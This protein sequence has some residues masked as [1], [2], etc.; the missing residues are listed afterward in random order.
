MEGHGTSDMAALVRDRDMLREQV[1]SLQDTNRRIRERWDEALEEGERWKDYA[2]ATEV[3]RLLARKLRA[4]NEALRVANQRLRD[5]WDE[6]C[7]NT[8]EAGGSDSDES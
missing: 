3:A 7:A 6:V 4:E 8:D 5:R 1:R 2:L